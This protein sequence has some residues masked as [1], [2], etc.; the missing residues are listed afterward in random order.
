M[1][2]DRMLSFFKSQLRFFFKKS[3]VTD[4]NQDMPSTMA[5]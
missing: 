5:T 4:R 3:N 2:S 1:I